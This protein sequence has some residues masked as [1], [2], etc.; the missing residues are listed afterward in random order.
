M[1]LLDMLLPAQRRLPLLQHEE[2]HAER[3]RD[4]AEE[5]HQH[6]AQ[7]ETE[8]LLRGRLLLAVGVVR[9]EEGVSHHRPALVFVEVLV[10]DRGQLSV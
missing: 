10:L 3:Q 8:G 4:D 1:P 7:V 2:V 6:A 5:H 9:W